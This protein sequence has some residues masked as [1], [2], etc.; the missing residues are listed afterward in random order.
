MCFNWEIS[1]LTWFFAI[2]CFIFLIKR[3]HKDDIWL[4]LFILTFST[5]QLLEALIWL[6]I[7]SPKKLN[8]I[9]KIVLIFLWLQPLVNCMA[10]F[11]TTK[12]AVLGI[13]AALYLCLLAYSTISSSS[14]TFTAVKGP[15]CHLV[16]KRSGSGHFM[17]SNLFGGIYLLGLFLPL[18][19]LAKP[20]TR[21]VAL[22]TAFITFTLSRYYYDPE[23]SSIWCFSSLL[24]SL[25]V[26]VVN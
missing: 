3:N 7:S 21:Y 19:F 13:G 23:F 16:W 17:K 26:I 1:L 5:I 18:L 4:A 14:E 22:F 6:N 12:V 20:I 25:S 11:I 10:G 8:I 24:F 15:N 9:T 2:A